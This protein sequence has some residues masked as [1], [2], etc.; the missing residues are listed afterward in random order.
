MDNFDFVMD[1]IVCIHI[2]NIKR[3]ALIDI[4]LLVICTKQHLYHAFQN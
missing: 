3:D 1:K 4:S 2:F